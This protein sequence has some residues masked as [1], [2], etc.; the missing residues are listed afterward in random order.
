MSAKLQ[1]ALLDALQ[2]I[3][4]A[5]QGQQHERVDHVGHRDLGLAHPDGFD[6]DHIKTGRLQQHHRFPGG[7]RHPTQRS[8]RRGRPDVGVRVHRQ[9]RHPGFITKNRSTRAGRRRVDRQHRH[10][11]PALDQMHAQRLDG[12]RLAHPRDPGD[13]DAMGVPGVRQQ[14]QQQLLRLLTMVGAG[15]LDQCDGPWQ[16]RTVTAAHGRRQ[17]VDGVVVVGCGHHGHGSPSA[18]ASAVL[19]LF[20]VAGVTSPR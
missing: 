12:S 5:G 19:I 6:Q 17:P 10:P 2:L 3:T 15:R 7:P 9:P 8:R 18:V 20:I 13:A 16:R 4:G 14:S 1:H 11:M